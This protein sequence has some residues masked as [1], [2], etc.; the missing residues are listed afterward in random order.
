MSPVILVNTLVSNGFID[1]RIVLILWYKGKQQPLSFLSR[2]FSV[3][4]NNYYLSSKGNE[5][6]DPLPHITQLGHG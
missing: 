1:Y 4:A 5:K 2:K 6:T 3:L